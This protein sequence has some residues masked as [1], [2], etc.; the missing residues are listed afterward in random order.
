M[1]KAL[2][3]ALAV[4]GVL[5]IMA[6]GGSMTSS[7][8][9]SPRT[10][11]GSTA[12]PSTSTTSKPALPKLPGVPF[13][14]LSPAQGVERVPSGVNSSFVSQTAFTF[15]AY[16]A[17][18]GFAGPVIVL[19]AFNRGT[20]P[21]PISCLVTVLG[22]GSQISRRTEEIVGP[23]S[24]VLN[25]AT[26]DLMVPVVEPHSAVT[27]VLMGADVKNVSIAFATHRLTVSARACLG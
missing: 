9:P 18:A 25:P 13:A 8:S 7:S 15:S 2:K 20:T 14:Y 17:R 4:V 16:E 24:G 22:G 6:I 27:G 12:L 3:I 23:M 26:G 19:R 21:L 5:V 10:A 1:P 11:G